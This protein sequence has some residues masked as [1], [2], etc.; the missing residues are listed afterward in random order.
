MTRRKHVG[1]A[2]PTTMVFLAWAV[3]TLHA[4]SGGG[5]TI[6]KSTIDS[7]GGKVTGGAY[8][9][10]GTVGQ[11]DAGPISGG[12]Y[13]LSGGFWSAS[14][15]PSAAP[16]TIAPVPYDRRKNRYISFAPNNPGQSVA[17][18][19]NKTTAPT[20][21]CW[22]QTP[23][24]SGNEQY[25]AKCNAT[26][27]FRVWTEPV[28]LV[29]DCEIIPVAGYDIAATSDGSA[30]SPSLT[31]GTIL[32]PALNSKLWGDTVGIN[33]GSEWTPPN[34]FTNVNDV[35]GILAYISN[36]AIRP[37]FTVANLQAISSA[38]SCLNAFVNTADVQISVRAISGD[39]YGPPNTSK[40]TDPALC[41]VCP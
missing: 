16:P 8:V 34:Q 6:K 24:P 38:D 12:G 9:L 14:N 2:M 4:Q 29:G 28:L 19:V 7:G 33:N 36:A 11:H 21:S 27:V 1:W 13:A 37:Q 30:F 31:V 40:I 15:G 23:V 18:R 17:F 39:S 3:P 35:L 32:L 5:Y 41:P 26:P 25:T 22:V 20:G 10:N